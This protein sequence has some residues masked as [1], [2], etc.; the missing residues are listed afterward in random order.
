MIRQ[1]LRPTTQEVTI[2]IPESYVGK[3]VEF[4]LFP[5]EV[6]T[7]STTN[8]DVD[9]PSLRGTFHEYANPQKHKMEATAWQDHIKKEYTNKNIRDK[10]KRLFDTNPT[11][12]FQN[13]EDPVSWQRSIRDEW[14]R[15]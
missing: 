2:K 4:L 1:I 14:D 15:V 3:D 12:P 11:R 10:M 7:M 5:V 9:I 8:S 13:I 6:T